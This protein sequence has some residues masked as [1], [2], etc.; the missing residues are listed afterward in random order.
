MYLDGEKKVLGDLERQ[1]KRALEAIDEKIAALLG[2]GDADMQHVIYRVEHQ[3]ALRIQV[4]A[5]LEQLQANEFET[6]SEYLTN[7]YNDG[8]VAA[9][10]SMHQ[11]DQ[12]FVVPIDQKQVVQAIQHDTKLSEDL[13][14]SLGEDVQRLKKVISAEISRGIA[15]G[16]GYGEIA[17]NIGNLSKAPLSRAKTIARTE[18]GRIQEQATIDAAAKSKAKGARIVKMWDAVRDGSTRSAHRQ[19]HGQ[20]REIEEPYE[21]G[22]K[23][24]MHPHGFGDPALDINC[25][26]TS[27]IMSKKLLDKTMLEEL[28]ENAKVWG[29][30]TTDSIE[31]FKKRYMKAAETVDKSGKSGIIEPGGTLDKFDRKTRVTHWTPDLKAANPYYTQGAEYKQNC[32]RCVPAYELRRRGYNVQAKPAVVTSS[33]ALSQNDPLVNGQKWL[34]GIFQNIRWQPA[35]NGTGIADIEKAMAQ[36]GDGA[37]AEVYVKWANGQGAHVFVAE[38]MDGKTHFFNPQS[39]S[40]NYRKAFAGVEKGFTMF[41]RIDNLSVTDAI[42]ECVENVR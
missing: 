27:V 24:A 23:K 15:S 11:Q 35:P 12:P 3:K 21:Y 42:E 10:Y 22:T 30:D 16:L 17:R 20:V 41:A 25:R 33:G 39:G 38:Q 5:I 13:Y 19:L 2:R 28:Q 40:S 1:Y 31:E 32:Q 7:S 4:Q 36:W 8:F 29:L 9:M 14:T 6:I 26:C 37:R 34:R 18:A